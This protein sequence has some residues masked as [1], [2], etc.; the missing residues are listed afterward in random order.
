MTSLLVLVLLTQAP[1]TLGGT[2]L[3]DDAPEGGNLSG[4]RG[5]PGIVVP[6]YVRFAP[7]NGAGLGYL[8]PFC[9]AFDVSVKGANWWCFDGSQSGGSSNAAGAVS[10]MAAY[11]VNSD[12]IDRICPNGPNCGSVSSRRMVA[13][14]GMTGGTFKDTSIEMTL[15]LYEIPDIEP[16]TVFMASHGTSS[17]TA[18]YSWFLADAISTTTWYVSD[19]VTPVSVSYGTHTGGALNF[20]CGLWSV[21][22]GVELCANSSCSA[23]SA[24]PV[25]QAI[26]AKPTVNGIN[27]T[28]SNNETGRV[29]G[30]F[31]TNKRMTDVQYIAISHALLGDQPQAIVRG[32]GVPPIT[33]SRATT[34]SVC[35]D[36]ACT[37]L[38]ILLAGRVAVAQSGY[39]GSATRQNFILRSGEIDNAAWANG[40]GGTATA[41]VVG[42][43]IAISPAGT[44]TATELEFPAVSGVSSFSLHYQQAT[45]VS[46]TTC[47]DAV[48]FKS[49]DGGTQTAAITVGVPGGGGAFC[50]VG[51]TWSECSFTYGSTACNNVNHYIVIGNDTRT[52]QAPDGGT[53]AGTAA[54]WG[55]L[56]WGGGVY[57]NW[58]SAPSYCPTTSVSA[59]CAA[60]VASVPNL[61]FTGSTL[62]ITSS[63]TPTAPFIAGETAF[64]L[65]LDANN[66]VKGYITSTGTTSTFT[67]DFRIATVSNTV[68]TAGNITPGVVT[69]VAC[70]Y[71]GINRAACLN[72][73]CTTTAGVLTLPTGTMTLWLSTRSVTTNEANGLG[74]NWCADSSLLKCVP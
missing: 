67:C 15:C 35:A 49:V 50:P 74:S 10:A 5:S 59:V 65:Q 32:V 2:P 4:T 43:N 37:A 42:K 18:G 52:G 27:G 61:S 62:S 64:Q 63:F 58:T 24:Q 36:A 1:P 19:G 14:S 48:W 28:V 13:T 22:G 41:P 8:P 29:L 71:D 30:A 66:D 3:L 73:V 20:Y 21:A 16:T 72:G 69:R 6:P 12:S 55:A 51:P 39:A 45:A 9:A 34:S 54:A 56:V 25:M 53:R 70:Y 33:F 23:P 40:A 38:S 31:W 17:L 26:T 7:V 47:A 44:L 57:H 46:A 11:G 68:A 60:D